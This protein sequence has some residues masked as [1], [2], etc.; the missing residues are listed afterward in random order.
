MVL[1]TRSQNAALKFFK[2]ATS[3]R[4]GS[5]AFHKSIA[6]ILATDC[7]RPQLRAKALLKAERESK[8]IVS[9]KQVSRTEFE[10][11]LLKFMAR[12]GMP[13]P[14]LY[15]AN[16]GESPIAEARR[17]ADARELTTTY[18]NRLF[19]LLK[20]CVGLWPAADAKLTKEWAARQFIKP[21][22]DLRYR[23][24]PDGYSIPLKVALAVSKEGERLICTEGKAHCD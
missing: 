20:T 22:P 6:S 23:M 17:L 15:Q 24:T 5:H 9:G 12:H 10:V 8:I 2:G 18:V 3:T 4:K 1:R 7:L 16:G 21:E 14:A 19:P 13:D 11:L